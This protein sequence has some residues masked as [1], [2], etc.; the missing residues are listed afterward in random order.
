MTVSV[1][2]KIA[3]ARVALAYAVTAVMIASSQIYATENFWGRAKTGLSSIYSNLLSL[4]LPVAGVCFLICCVCAFFSTNPQSTQ[5][6]AS[7]GK[8]ILLIYA[9]IMGV[10]YIFVTIKEVVGDSTQSI[11]G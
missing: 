10:G 11:F 9:L 4:T 6:W 3:L 5:K 1:N 7:Y 8:R 2:R